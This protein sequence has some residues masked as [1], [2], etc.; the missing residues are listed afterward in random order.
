MKTYP[1]IFIGYFGE[2]IF[3]EF[4]SFEAAARQKPHLIFERVHAG[5]HTTGF[6][7]R[8]PLYNHVVMTVEGDVG[9]PFSVNNWSIEHILDG[10]WVW[11]TRGVSGQVYD[12]MSSYASG[13]LATISDTKGVIR[14]EQ[15]FGLADLFESLAYLCQFS[16][17]SEFD[18]ALKNRA[19]T[20]E[21]EYLNNELSD[22]K[23]NLDESS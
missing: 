7:N 13:F 17:W 1:T 6:G 3:T 19:L 18:L 21:V 16:T 8:H 20:R 10:K 14:T 5:N 4:A 9:L 11:K 22:L 2:G 23:K 12:G 15:Y